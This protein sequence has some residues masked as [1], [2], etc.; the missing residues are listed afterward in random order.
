[1]A[2]DWATGVEDFLRQPVEPQP[3]APRLKQ[4]MVTAA[5]AKP[6][7]EAELRRA[8]IATGVPLDS[9]RSDPKYVLGQAKTLALDL[10]GL[11][12]R[13][14]GTANFL[15][16]PENARIAHDDVSVLEKIEGAL[17]N[18]GNL[19]K[20]SFFAA[21]SGSAGYLQG[22]APMFDALG[23]PGAGDLD[24]P[25]S[26]MGQYVTALRKASKGAAEHYTPKTTNPWAAGVNSGVISVFQ[27]APLTAGA[28]LSKNPAMAL[29]G[30]GAITAGNAYG[31]AKDKGKSDTVARGYAGAQ[32]AI[33]ILTE[34]IP[35]TALL[36]DVEKNTGFL[37]TLA[38]QLA[39][40]AP[41]EQIA[42]LTQD[43]NEWLV[44]NPD[45]PLSDFVKER[46]NA[47]I[48]TLVASALG[49]TSNATVARLG[50]LASRD[51][52]RGAKAVEAQQQGLILEQLNTA[53]AA[54]KLRTRDPKTFE[55]FI[56]EATKEGPV[57]HVYVDPRVIT[58]VLA[59]GDATSLADNAALM[60]SMPSLL[61]QMDQALSMGGD[62]R[63][64][65]SEFAAYLAGSNL[66]QGLMPHLKTDPA[67]MSLAESET[68]LQAHGEEL[69]AEVAEIVARDQVEDAMSV[70]AGKVQAQVLDQLAAANRFTPDVN[71]AYATLTT[72][73]YATQAQ[74]LGITPE[75]MFAAHPVRIAAEGVTGS[76]TLDAVAQF[77]QL[78]KADFA[79]LLADSRAATA[80]RKATATELSV[81]DAPVRFGR[82]GDQ[83]A[84]V[85]PDL[86]QPGRW[87]LTRVDAAGPSG[88]TEYATKAEAVEDALRE[89]YTP[90][91]RSPKRDA[92]QDW[93]QVDASD[94]P[95]A[96]AEVDQDENLYQADPV[97][98]P[99]V[100]V[101][102]KVYAAAGTHFDALSKAFWEGAGRDAALDGNNRG[103]VN[104]KGQFLSR[105]R[106]MA[107]AV[108]NDLLDA[109]YQGYS[110]APELVAEWLKPDA[111]GLDPEGLG[112]GEKAPRGA[113]N[114]NTNLITLLAG[115]DL[116]TFLHE[117][118]HFYLETTARLAA[119][120][121]GAEVFGPDVATVLDFMGHKGLTPAEWLA[122]PL[123]E[124]RE[125]H[126]LF[127][128]GFEA[129]LMEGKSPSQELRGVFQRF[130][131]WLT[132]VYKTL[133]GLK[134]ELNDDVRAVFDRMLASER[135]LENNA[136]AKGF[137]PLFKSA[138]E[139]GLTPQEWESY[140]R[141]GSE[142]AV[143]AVDQLERRSIRD[144]KWLSGAKDKTLRRL[145][146]Q[147]NEKRKAV[148]AEVTA[149]LMLVPVNRAR[150]FLKRG[151]IDGQ[152]V[153]GPTKL[154][155][156]ELRDMYPGNAQY[157]GGGVDYKALGFGK[158]GM[159][160]EDGMHP[161]QVAELFGFSSGDELVR[162]LIAAPALKDE[163]DGL[164]D[165]RML[166]RYGDLADQD[167]IDK[168]A[169]EALHTDARLRFVA[170]EANA[171]AKA[172]GGRRMMAEA[173]KGYAADMIARAKIRDLKPSRYQSAETRAAVNA[174]KAAKAGDLITAATEKRNQV[175]NGYATKAVYE[176]QE[177]VDKALRYFA[178]LSS[179]GARKAL[180]ADYM[181][182]IDALLERYDLRKG[183]TLKDIDKRK[184]LAEWIEKQREMGLDPIIPDEL[185][186]NL[187]RKP[188][189]EM[190]VDEMRG[191]V[192]SVRNI[193][194][195]GR[196]KNR[197]LTA[198]RNRDFQ[199]TVAEAVE[200]ITANATSK[201][202]TA[203]E[204]NRWVDRAEGGVREFFAMHRK[205]SS[206]IR[207][208][209]GFSDDN[210][211][212]DVLVRP[213]NVASDTEAVMRETSTKEL[214]RVLT[215]II[216]EKLR[217]KVFI[218][219]INNS[220][221][222]EG[223]LMVAMN[224]G[225][226]LNRARI[227]DGDNWTEAQ[228]AAILRTLTPQQLEVVQGVWD[229]IDSYWPQIAAKERRV[230]GTTPEKV[231][232]V[233]VV[234]EAS[235]GTLVELRGGYFPIKYDPARSTKAESDSMA[236]I[237]RQ[238]LQ[239][240]HTRA[241]TRRG[242]TKKRV[243]KVERPVRKDF[244][245]IFQHVGEVTH[246]LAWHEYLIDANRLLGSAGIDGVIRDFYGREVLGTMRKALE[247]MAL[248]DVPAANV[249][250][251]SI[252]HVRT[253]ATVAGL[254]WNIVT[255]AL[256]P[257]GLTQS[258]VRIGPK[259]VAKGMSR[260]LRD[261]ASMQNTVAWVN[262]RSPFMRLRS[263]TMQR[264]INEVRNKV[265]ASIKPA[266]MTAV[267][268]SFFLFI[269][270]AQMIA[271]MPT[272]LGQYEKS[273]EAGLD[274][275][276]AVAQADQAVRDS[277][278]SG[279]IADLAEIQRGG[280]LQKLFTNFYSF[281]NVTYNLLAETTA[282]TRLAGPS[283]LPVLAVDALL[284]MVVPSVLGTILKTAMKG[285]D[286]EELP[287][288]L[289]ADNIS[290]MLGMMVGLREIG[291]IFSSDGRSQAPAGLRIIGE[292]GR[293]WAQIEQGEADEAFWKAANNAAGILFHYPAG[294]VQ[295]T[296]TG[297]QA[298]ANGE[299]KNPLAPVVGPPP[300]N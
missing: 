81:D 200:L 68:F 150:E 42:T 193:A 3:L 205:F 69:Q 292:L 102:G 122:L 28:I 184:S 124:R 218:P 136:A 120:P 260:W 221:S 41:G 251:R 169:D 238:N 232:P 36:G 294:Q 18:L 288:K 264:E 32:G 91:V 71:E 207:Q 12:Y 103:F 118:G 84:L 26:E 171:L 156:P 73:F 74:R 78:S 129:Y 1:M 244:G 57:E 166:E 241:T 271:D 53:A 174:A 45:K 7:Y 85:S 116:S 130:R 293:L 186:N 239:G 117:S 249:F 284:L 86:E 94:A 134:V 226:E 5:D 115:A 31:D 113:Y 157:P 59:Q 229:H 145:Q 198:K 172:T 167:A 131:A 245:V 155:L 270:K 83:R 149:E 280:P 299:T 109:R 100:K 106:A 153:E 142:A 237:I 279:Q 256:Q 180:D 187:T 170:T 233:P 159:V 143:D 281:F 258:M 297:V 296:V 188:Y 90:L 61:P 6:D 23:I 60:Q 177:D 15:A 255:S 272:W 208:M 165:Q 77:A 55:A 27:N 269:T 182:Q 179:P 137:A 82:D 67:G 79:K 126:E 298:M 48:S 146:R 259:W 214:H 268:S 80:K 236:D 243:E 40:D 210:L 246:D 262:E 286:W 253:G 219:E 173:A 58:E 127:A 250:E 283:R 35:L 300:K 225:N 62:V 25:N 93:E 275:D 141:L 274:E 148:R 140:Q 43:F 14:P 98:R 215:P 248:G 112:Q 139:A 63:I 132:T 66:A 223:R 96:D 161:E 267:E 263:T 44:L 17:V 176:A 105:K 128:R 104:H 39:L 212:W 175:L 228:V 203:I 65:V 209:A 54:S 202:R 34:K 21:A 189:R 114:P 108:E 29:G 211:L 164:T 64:P 2:D 242:H 162:A 181:D 20:A 75:A 19:G 291:S 4:S 99:A 234:I 290:Y 16:Q 97:L 190:T 213:M 217:A 261:A 121:E 49:S 111:M 110:N 163:I 11:T 147:A 277:Q 266:A 295:R 240:A 152:E 206:L 201:A 154:S 133:T 9:A 24:D 52:E 88:H 194:H 287:E 195:L 254:G 183:V 125:G 235:D 22:M 196:L 222:L 38:K 72:A 135:Q 51:G 13:A 257:L 282:E 138:E 289:V 178:R 10:D 50:D 101:N 33:E 123:D 160:A 185:V 204:S 191:L 247:D 144:M 285:D 273:M 56:A 87:R 119:S 8:S 158:Y 197:L 265:T 89:K 192:D 95:S 276:L 224:W 199:A 252:N 76:D 37:K 168:A 220:L 227:M 70:S 230:T 151:T 47:A 278:G 92:P 30:M 216:G 231:E 107:Y 46:P